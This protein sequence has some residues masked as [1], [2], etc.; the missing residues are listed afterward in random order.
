[1]YTNC[2]NAGDLLGV[3]TAE[4][5]LKEISQGIFTKNVKVNIIDIQH[6]PPFLCF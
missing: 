1:M 6:S 4:S 2:K 5:H 3:Q